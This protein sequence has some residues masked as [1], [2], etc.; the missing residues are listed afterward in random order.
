MLHSPDS[1]CSIEK[2]GLE[3]RL[4]NA[5]W[6]EDSDGQN[7]VQLVAS[8]CTACEIQLQWFKN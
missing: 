1:M 2:L 4:I 6:D 8:T 5:Q 3:I 7:N